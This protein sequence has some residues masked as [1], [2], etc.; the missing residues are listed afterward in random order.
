MTKPVHALCSMF[1]A[2]AAELVVAGDFGK[3]VAF[4]GLGVKG[5]KISEAIGRLKTVPR[6]R[7]EFPWEISRAVTD[8]DTNRDSPGCPRRKPGNAP[9]RS[10]GARS[11]RS[12]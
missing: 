8:E 5:V 4:T 1:G 12:R 7:W 6:G 9:G 11:A 10:N 2:R 3:M